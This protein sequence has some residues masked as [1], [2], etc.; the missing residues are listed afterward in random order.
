[1]TN[2][3]LLNYLHENFQLLYNPGQNLSVDEAMIKFPGVILAEAVHAHEA[4]KAR[5][6]SM[7]IGG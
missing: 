1:M 2:R 4:H 3:P 7:D 6:K 5:N